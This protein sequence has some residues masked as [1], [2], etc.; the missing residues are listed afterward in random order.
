MAISTHDRLGISLTLFKG[1]NPKV[2]GKSSLKEVLNRI[3]TSN[4]SDLDRTE[5]I[6]GLK[7]NN[8]T[9]YKKQKE[10]LPGFC[11]GN[12][13][14]RSQNGCKEYFPLLI[15]DID[16]YQDS[17]TALMDLNKLKHLPEVLFS[18][19]SPSGRGLRIGVWS[20][21]TKENHTNV[22]NQVG[23][24]ISKHLKIPICRNSQ[25]KLSV[26]EHLDIGRSSYAN[27][28]F[29][30]PVRADV[31]FFLNKDSKTYIYS[32]QKKQTQPMKQQRKMLAIE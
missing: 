30:T 5:K 14:T 8:P 17:T 3:S 4:E 27:L 1:V 25:E 11:V 32:P 16:G 28:W 18:F 29:Y 20:N 7:N 10:K 24:L 26:K 31:E 15:F 13:T 21:A 12:Y 9:V 19:L 6:R 2:Q 22:Y 23:R